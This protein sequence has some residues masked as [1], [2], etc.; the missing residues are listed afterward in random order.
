M[1]KV[2]HVKNL[3]PL[4]TLSSEMRDAHIQG[5]IK[6]QFGGVNSINHVYKFKFCQ[7][8]VFIQIH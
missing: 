8:C 4:Y 1:Q 6:S 2:S 7:N 3:L 5:E